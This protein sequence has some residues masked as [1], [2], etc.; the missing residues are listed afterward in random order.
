M[1]KLKWKVKEKQTGR[2]A[3]F[4]KRGWPG[5][6]YDGTDKAAVSI[7]CK[8]DYHIQLAKSGNHQPLEVWIADYNFSPGFKWRKVTQIFKTLNEAKEFALEFLN[9]HPELAPKDLN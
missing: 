5:A 6:H 3:A 4:H 2:Y 1:I 8:D 9:K 7:H